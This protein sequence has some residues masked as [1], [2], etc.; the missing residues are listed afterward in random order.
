MLATNPHTISN[1]LLKTFKDL[2]VI[3]S[4]GEKSFFYNPH[5]LFPRGTYFCTIKESD[6]ENDKASDL[7]RDQVFRLNFGISKPTFID[8][9]QT[10][11]ARPPKGGVIDGSYDFT[12]L[13]TLY[14]H[15]VYGW[16]CWIA[17][18]NPSEHSFKKLENLLF[19]SYQLVLQKHQKKLKDH[20]KSS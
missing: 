11:P 9:F 5:S 17:I 8:L 7:N 4:W 12:K 3:N 6:G 20:M 10:I 13:D 16:M 2:V 15:P 14:P 19:E 1:Y 18:V